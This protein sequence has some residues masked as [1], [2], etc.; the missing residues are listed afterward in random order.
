MKKGEP[1]FLTLVEIIEIQRNQLELY[2]G[3][4]GIRDYKLLTSAVFMAESTFDGEFLHEN[5]FDMAAAYAFHICQNHPFI[6]GNKRVAL[7]A[8][9][10]FLD[11]NGIEITDDEGELFSAMMKVARGRGSK[12]GLSL[13]FRRLASTICG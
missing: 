6:D 11:F 10:V 5:L 3:D 9:L 1:D 4:T 12:E 13:L 2:G 7:V 8:A